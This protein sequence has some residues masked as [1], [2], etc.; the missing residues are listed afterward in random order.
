MCQW[1]DCTGLVSLR[2]QGS[3]DIQEPSVHCAE[4]AASTGIP[5]IH[6]SP[7]GVDL[8]WSS[9]GSLW[10]TGHAYLSIC[11]L[12]M[13]ALNP[14]RCGSYK[15][16]WRR[17]N[18]LKTPSRSTWSEDEQSGTVSYLTSGWQETS[19]YLLAIQNLPCMAHLEGA[20]HFPLHF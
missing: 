5:M 16:Y 9:L 17:G 20:F 19:S 12:H 7:G 13:V 11:T 4:P 10:L 3:S 2:K 6:T 1:Q 8:F 18:M 15:T 14:G